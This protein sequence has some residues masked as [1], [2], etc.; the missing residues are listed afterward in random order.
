MRFLKVFLVSILIL[1]SLTG[2][3]SGATPEELRQAIENKNKELQKVAGEIK[4]TQ[5]QL[6]KIE[7]EKRTLNRDIKGIDYNINQLNLGIRSSEINIEKLQLELE[8]LQ[9][10]RVETESTIDIQKEGI[11]EVLREIQQKDNVSLMHVLLKG[12][13]LADSLFEIQNLQDLQSNLSLNVSSLTQLHTD[14]QQNIVE[15]SDTKTTLEIE[16]ANFKNRKTIAAEKKTEKKTLLTTTKNIESVYQKQLSELES[17]QEGIGKE[18]GELED[19]LRASFDTN[20]LPFKRSGILA[21]PV[22]DTLVTQQY[23]ATAFAQRAY[24]TK[25][26]NGV[27]FKAPI[28][29]PIIAADNGTV[30]DIGNNGRVQYGKYVLIKHDNNLATLYA[31]LSKHNVSKG[32]NVKVGQV[33]GYSGNTGYSTGP[34]L[35]FTVYW[36]PSLTLKSFPGAGLVPVGVTIN[37]MDYL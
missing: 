28:G 4:Q 7:E 29:T 8:L 6:E 26:H 1:I 22:L 10:K 12:N 5:E 34:H 35:H 11:A 37:P 16:N 36:A 2:I 25:F 19:S 17:R 20:V 33:I 3:A 15:T 13:S 31:H 18:I 14:L 27:D 30:M 21:Y 23:G 9:D 32:D 24:K